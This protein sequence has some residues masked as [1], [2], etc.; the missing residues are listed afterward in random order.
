MFDKTGELPQLFESCNIHVTC[1]KGCTKVNSALSQWVM[2]QSL[3]TTD[4]G[5]LPQLMKERSDCGELEVTFL[6]ACL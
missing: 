6:K 5:H 3:A 4:L 1:L 2:P